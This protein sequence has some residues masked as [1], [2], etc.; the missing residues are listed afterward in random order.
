MPSRRRKV[1][2]VAADFIEEIT[3]LQRMDAKNQTKFSAL[4]RQKGSL[5][6]HE[7]HFQT[8]AIFFAAFRAYES[9]IRDIFILYCQ[10]KPTGMG[11]RVRSFL[12]PRDSLHAEA[13]IQSSMPFLDWSSPD[14]VLERAELYLEGGF[15]IRTPYVTNRD[16]FRDLRRIRNHIAHN[17]KES[18]EE[19]KRVVKK[20]YRTIPLNTPS[21]GEFLLQPE[22]KSKSYKLQTYLGL[23]KAVSLDLS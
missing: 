17:S 8:E 5:S 1:S 2:A 22:R 13:L 18:L 16:T 23:L 21:P 6:K 14:T 9:F 15:P 4:K 7:L 10:E 19:Y 20:H 3:K 12:K 11:A